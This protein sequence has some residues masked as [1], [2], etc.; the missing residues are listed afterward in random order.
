MSRVEK[1]GCYVRFIVGSKC[2]VS[3]EWNVMSG[4]ER[5]GE[6]KERGR[7]SRKG[8]GEHQVLNGGGN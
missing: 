6:R 4:A 5:D 8:K 2:S 7:T 3:R 1:K